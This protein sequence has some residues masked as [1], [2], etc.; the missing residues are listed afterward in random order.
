MK[1]KTFLTAFMILLVTVFSAYGGTEYSID[2]IHSFVGFSVRHLVI[3][4]VKGNFTDYSGTIN[5]DE[6]DVSKSAVELTIKAASIDTDNENRDGHLTNEDFFDVAQYPDIVFKSDKIEKT[7]DG[8]IMHGTLT[9][10]GVTKE[11]SIPFEILGK[12][13]M[14]EKEILAIEGNAK[15]SRKD[16]GMTWNKVL[17]AGGLALSD[18]I[19]IELH[20]EAIKM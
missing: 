12:I 9:M 15:L 18:E 20:I 3:S 13:T 6:Q 4:T 7:E 2:K 16:Y 8:F 19:K 17:E 1:S 5:Y 14:G 10:H 11:I